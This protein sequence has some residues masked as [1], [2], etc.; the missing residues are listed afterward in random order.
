MTGG[1]DETP[2]RRKGRRAATGNDDEALWRALASTV[3]PL[4][5]RGK[6]ARPPPKATPKPARGKKAPADAAPERTT[7]AP[8]PAIRQPPPRPA[9]PAIERR[10]VQRLSRARADAVI[11]LHG[12][13]QMEAR[14]ALLAFLG[15]AR[16]DGR[17]FVLVITGKGMM[18]GEEA[19]GGEQAGVL[20][21]ALPRW[22]AEA[23]F[24][25]LVS[26]HAPAHRRH[27]GGGAFYLR[28]RRPGPKG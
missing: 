22:L 19:P 27:G 10:T 24:R 17:R 6:T 20:R 2:G 25:A 8:R 4:E 13:R 7:G 9:P 15:R 21:Q 28:L 26:G 18:R 3:R 5:R 14:A 11:D 12:L 23:P 16:D 1:R